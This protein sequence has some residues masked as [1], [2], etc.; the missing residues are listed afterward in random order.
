MK[1]LILGAGGMLGHLT[2]CYL[3]EKF[4]SR[5][6][7]AARKPTGLS[8]IDD[9]LEVLDLCDQAKLRD[10]ITRHRPCVVVNCAAVN[11]PKKGDEMMRA[12]NSRLPQ[13]VA[14]ILDEVKDTSRLIHI[15][16]DGVFQGQRGQYSEMDAPDADDIYGKS[17]RLGEVVHSPHL[18]VRTSI[19][20]PDPINARGLLSWYLSQTRDVQGFTRVFW[21]GVTTLELAQFIEFACERDISGMYHLCSQRISKYD[22][23]KTI[24]EVFKKGAVIHQDGHLS[25]DLSLVSSRSEV[26]YKV[27]DIKHMLAQLKTWMSEH[28]NIYQAN[29]FR[30]ESKSGS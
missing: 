28:P 25:V 9:G 3:K 18:T 16:T 10:L 27:A 11:D 20:G 17:K 12:V 13:E 19:I 7:V 15:S 6:V 30:S 8:V 29:V 4:A 21:S 23:L 26:D 22:L 5:V 1:I 24:K 14:K 2:G